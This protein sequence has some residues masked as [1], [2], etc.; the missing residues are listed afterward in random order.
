[1]GDVNRLL[2]DDAMASIEG[3]LD[4]SDAAVSLPDASG[5]ATDTTLFPADIAAN[6]EHRFRLLRPHARGGLGEVFVAV[7]TELNR[8]VALKQIH[9]RHADDP[10]PAA[11]PDGG[12]DHR[13]A[14]APRASSPSTGSA[15]I[16]AAGPLRDAVHHAE[17][18]SG[19]RSSSSTPISARRGDPG[20]RA[21]DLRQLLRRFVDVCNAVAYA[22]SRGVLHRDLKPGNVMVGPYGETLVVDWGLA[23]PIGRSETQCPRP[24]TT[25]L[26]ASG[27]GSAATLTGS[28][29]G[30]PAYMS[31]EQAVGDLDRLGPR[32]DVYS[33]GAT[34]YCLLTGK[35]ALRAATSARSSARSDGATSRRR[36]NSTRRSTRRSRRSA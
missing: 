28:A 11:V 25:L 29:L 4:L 14:G 7:D 6:S 3:F 16:R 21:L 22:H 19:K 27:S 31:P 8:E 17:T 32:S 36:G 33:L 1:M 9:D 10:Q 5:R 30:T 23:K 34:L 20:Q 2:A 18:A 24:E 35:A 13:R 26:P 15:P 12:G